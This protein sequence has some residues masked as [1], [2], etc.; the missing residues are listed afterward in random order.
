MSAL[1]KNLLSQIQKNI[2]STKEGLFLQAGSHQFQSFWTRDFCFASLGLSKVGEF[3]VVRNHLTKLLNSMNGEGLIP[4]ILES[5]FSKKTVILNTIFRFLPSNLKKSK[6]HKKLKAEYYGEHGTISID[7]NALVIIAC[8]E[9][10]LFS[11]DNSFLITNK[12]KL[13]K[14]F[15]F[16]QNKLKDGLIHQK[17]F[18][19][20]QDSARREGK[21]FY[22]NLLYFEAAKKLVEVNFIEFNLDFLKQTIYSEFLV[23][24]IF[25]NTKD[26]SQVSVEANYLAILFDF[27]D[28]ELAKKML[29]KLNSSPYLYN[30]LPLCT[31]PDYS[32]R[33]ISWTC[34][35]VGLSNY[36][37]EMIW[38]WIIGLRLKVLYKLEDHQQAT[39]LL[40]IIHAL[41]LKHGHIYEIFEVDSHKP[42]ERIFYRS[43][44]PF[45]WGIGIILWAID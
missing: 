21:I 3:E 11:G 17:E 42:T 34:K 27:V 41:N 32:S 19:D 18:E 26:S 40:Q 7:S 20:W 35:A 9:Y 5:S 10:A 2:I 28:S 16:Y 31:Y 33:E 8:F 15:E 37:D 22:T 30:K 1:K 23:E 25:I 38:S 24:D 29:S 43:E 14:C 6:H 12:A 39:E 13:I 44:H 4:R 36:H 45:S